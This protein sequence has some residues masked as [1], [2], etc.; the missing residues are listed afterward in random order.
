MHFGD[1][2][3]NTLMRMITFYTS[4]LIIERNGKL[5]TLPL[6]ESAKV[7]AYVGHSFVVELRKDWKVGSTTYSKGTLLGVKT[8]IIDQGK[9]KPADVTPL[10]TPTAKTSVLT[11]G[12]DARVSSY[13]HSGHSKR[14]R[15]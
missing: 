14:G 8:S 2:S 3:I 5:K 10:F 12:C 4:E 9:V 13:Q 1:R 11:V 6:Q 7:W 15:F